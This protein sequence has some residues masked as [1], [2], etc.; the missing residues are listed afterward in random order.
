MST[1]NNNLELLLPCLRV[2]IGQQIILT[3]M[4]SKV[5][6]TVV[7][8]HEEKNR[9]QKLADAEDRSLSYLAGK[10]IRDGLSKA[11]SKA[12]TDGENVA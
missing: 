10:F 7:L 4:P 11:E 3:S 2:K 8:T 5:T 9:L 1:A 6:V 12:A